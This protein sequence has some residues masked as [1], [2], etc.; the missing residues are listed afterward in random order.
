MARM[1]SMFSALTI[2][3]IVQFVLTVITLGLTASTVNS[4]NTITSYYGFRSTSS[5]IDNFAVFCSVW[6]L[7]VIAYM[8]FA[9]LYLAVIA[10][11]IISLVVDVITTIFW[12]SAWI[13]L[14]SQWAPFG[15]CGG[16]SGCKTG[17]ASIAFACFT[18]L[19]FLASTILIILSALPYF[20]SNSFSSRSAPFLEGGAFPTTSAPAPGTTGPVGAPRDG[21]NIDLEANQSNKEQFSPEVSYNAPPVAE[22]VH[23]HNVNSPPVAGTGI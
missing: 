19:A 18:W 23:P 22:P 8:I 1:Q 12:F 10:V 3:R 13:A 7:L 17:K 5:S 15:R 9:P 11:P 20:K 21:E 2:L 16:W 14:A 6:S 4:E